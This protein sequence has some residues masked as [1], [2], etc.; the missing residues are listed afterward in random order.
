MRHYLTAACGFL[1]LCAL[2]VRAA[3]PVEQ[4]LALADVLPPSQEK[5]S[6]VVELF[7]SQGCVSCPPADDFFAELAQDP[8]VIALSLHV[9]Y[10]DYIGWAD[11][12]AHPAFTERQKTYARAI[13]SRTIYTPQF[14]VGGRDRIEGFDPQEIGASVLAQVAQGVSV[15]LSTKRNAGMLEIQAR[16]A[17]PFPAPVRIELVRYL[18]EQT[19]AIERGENEGQVITYR[20]IVTNWTTLGEWGGVE[21]LALAVPVEGDQPAVVILQASGPAQILAADR[22]D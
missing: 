5:G 16:S 20:N 10:W 18:P 19:V 1:M 11:S 7:T 21:P 22:V 12:F 6:V 8:R 13:G 15:E 3:D 14:V 4:P 17:S 2:P 9:D